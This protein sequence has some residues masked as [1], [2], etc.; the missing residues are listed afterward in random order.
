[1]RIAICFIYLH[2]HDIMKYAMPKVSAVIPNYNHARFLDERIQSVFNQNYRDFEVIILDDYS[3]DNS[4]KAIERYRDSY[5]DYM[6]W[7]E[8]ANC[9]R[10][11]E[12][13][14][15]LDL[16]SCHRD[17]VTIK[18]ESMDIAYSELYRIYLRMVE[19]CNPTLLSLYRT[20]SM[21]L[22]RLRL[23]RDK[24]IDSQSSLRD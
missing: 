10:V 17:S 6:F 1:M 4:R 22:W 12:V 20:V 13:P 18:T 23:I 14:L 2:N 19:L 9:G 15:Y 11:I 5:G 16:F 7:I 8:L 21:R 24:E 3:T